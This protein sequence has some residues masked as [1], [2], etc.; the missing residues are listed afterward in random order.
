MKKVFAIIYILFL[1]LNSRSQSLLT[2]FEV[3]QGK[4]TSTYS[5]CIKFYELIDKKYSSI[6]IKQ[7]NTTDAGYP[8]H[9]VLFSADNHFNIDVWHK[10]K[11][12][13]LI[14]NGIH[15]GE[16]DG[17]DASMMLV[18]DLATG[19]IDAPK[20]VVLGFIAV[21]NIGGTLNRNNYSRV[22]QQ[23]PESYGFR[24]NAQNLDLNRDFTKNDSRNA[25][26]FATI[27]HYL[28]PHIFIDNHVSDGADF[29]HTMTLL[30]SQHNK[31]GEV[32]GSFLHNTFEPGL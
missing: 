4:R 15:P 27:F 11:V 24:G 26:T 19:K 20:N 25:R 18:R 1:T 29:Q 32:G 10:N 16:P 23:G 13:I 2:P 7:F 22:N 5:D 31:L 28:K 6:L 3:F 17:I 21:Y 12:V 8:L 30:S 14:N 9:L